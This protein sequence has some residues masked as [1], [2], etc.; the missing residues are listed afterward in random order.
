MPICFV[1]V[2]KFWLWCVL[3]ARFL[4][5][6]LAFGRRVAA[7]CLATIKHIWLTLPSSTYTFCHISSIDTKA[8]LWCTRPSVSAFKRRRPHLQAEK[9]A[10]TG[11]RF[12]SFHFN[13]SDSTRWLRALRDPASW[14]IFEKGPRE[15][16]H[17]RIRSDPNI[18]AF[19]DRRSAK[20]LT[21]KHV[22]NETCA[23]VRNACR[24]FP[25]LAAM[26]FDFFS[27]V[28]CTLLPDKHFFS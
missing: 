10:S 8:L 21:W 26:P 4:G 25:S 2:Y 6:Q 1:Y 23:S 14:S 13:D 3:N 12:F 15:I 22:S 28:P 18:A 5:F 27:N 11:R 16:R 19:N 17:I 9:P 7:A 24:I 20:L